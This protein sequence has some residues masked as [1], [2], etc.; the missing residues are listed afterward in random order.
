M[1]KGRLKP[2]LVFIAMTEVLIKISNIDCAACVER[3]DRALLALPGVED[4]A[5]SYASGRAAVSYDEARLTLDELVRAI[6]KAGFGVPFDRVQLTYGALTDNAA[7]T[8]KT[9]LLRV[10]GVC[11]V[12]LEKDSCWVSLWPIGVDSRKLILAARD[13]GVWAELGQMESGEEEAELSHRFSILRTLIVAAALTMPLMWD[14]PPLVQFALATLIQFGP[15]LFFYRNAL[16]ALRNKTL[17]MDQLIAL[18]ITLIYGY[19]S[20]IAFTATDEIKLYF[21]CQGVLV[22][23]I[24]FGR[25]LEVLAV[26]QTKASVRKL[27]R[28]QP[29]TALVY[30]DG[31]EKELS[32]DEIEEHDTLLVRPGERIPVDGVVLEGGC[33]VD[34]SML[35]GESLPV[36]KQAGDHVVGGTLNRSGSVK[37]AA[38]RLGKDS[39]LQQIVDM[40]QHGQTSKAPI[41]RLADKIASIFVPVILGI[42]V[43][44]F[45]IWIFAVAPHDLGKAVYTVCGVLVIACPCALGLATPTALMVGSGRASELGILF[46]GGA[47]LERAYKVDTVVFDKTGTLTLGQPEVVDVFTAQGIDAAGLIARA[48]ALERLSEHPLASAIVRYAAYRYPNTLPPAVEDFHNLPGLGVIGT[49]A[50]QHV[51][52]GNRELL[53]R[54]GIDVTQLPSLD[55]RILTEVCVAVGGKLLGA[56]YVADRLRSGAKEAVATLKVLGIEVWMLT[57]DNEG[58]AQAVAAQCGIDRVL[59]R[60]LPDEKAAAIE[61][62][63]REKKTVAMV[64]DGINDAP[65]LAAADLAVA[66]GTGT[67]IA[68]DCAHVVLPGGD[69]RKVPLALK[70]SRATI[71]TVRQSFGWALLYNT[72]CIPVAALGVLNPSIAAAAMALSSNGV[73]LHSLRLNKYEDGNN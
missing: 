5:T 73:L 20:V 16:R 6:Q 30:R 64:G 27:L 32:L 58:T 52:C 39:V 72:I 22:T 67:D 54:D 24:L 38:T 11:K 28:L 53:K 12:T 19:C 55:E 60:V 69:L 18:S 25:Y 31:E 17:G 50:G 35:T 49:V 57:G 68:I 51:V 37:I 66:M 48:V 21:L 47:E 29:K 61:R 46:K 63:K 4:V 40:V 62:L 1:S 44:V 65:A 41:Q 42:A 43:L 33:S 15:G 14:L 45:A 59:A 10:P 71:L 23:L 3:I 56:L 2:P 8:L 9:A 7:E 26:N 36:F 70:L 34:E 13:A